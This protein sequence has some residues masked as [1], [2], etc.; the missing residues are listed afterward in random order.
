LSA[1][2]NEKNTNKLKLY[3]GRLFN[4]YYKIIIKEW[5]NKND[6]ENAS[7]VVSFGRHFTQTG[8]EG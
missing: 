4:K 5:S 3:H 6:G 2:I 7:T 1:P 8:V